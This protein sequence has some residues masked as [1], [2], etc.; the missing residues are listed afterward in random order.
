ML[1]E[2]PK[3]VV[4][5]HRE[6]RRF[7]SAIVQWLLLGVPCPATAAPRPRF[8]CSLPQAAPSLAD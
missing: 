3:F 4:R 2:A 6:L 7:I 1:C 5:K 8:P